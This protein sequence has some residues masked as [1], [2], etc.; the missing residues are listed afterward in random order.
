MNDKFSDGS[1]SAYVELPVPA[2][3]LSW[4]RGNATLKAI[5][6]SDPGMYFGGWRAFVRSIK[7]N[8]ELPSLPIPRVTRTSQDGRHEYEVYATNVLNFL[9]VQHR[10]RFEMRE[11]T[12]DAETGREY[13][14]V[15]AVSSKR[16]TGYIPYRQIFGLVF[17]DN[18][19]EFNYGVMKVYNWSGFISLE[20]AGQT[21]N[22]VSVPKGQALIRRYGS[23]GTKDG[24]P[25]FET[26]GQGHS[27]P[28]EAI[29][30]D[31]PRFYPV[32]DELNELWDAALP[33]KECERWNANGEVEEPVETSA[34]QEFLDQCIALYLTNEEIE[35]ILAENDNN[36][37]KA[38]AA[39]QGDSL[40]MMNSAA[41]DGDEFPF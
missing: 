41:A 5:A 9:P 14:K 35:Q 39:L 15:V 10:T 8:V 34:K 2:A 37:A 40:E 17:A 26:F 29:G 6:E 25:K 16:L 38:L 24:R 3:Y 19:D 27:T 21:W 13:D 36:Y 18:S 31:S 33:W 20:K 30:L 12:V 7:E 22:K 1:S 4:T 32:T 11:K 23:V 28:I